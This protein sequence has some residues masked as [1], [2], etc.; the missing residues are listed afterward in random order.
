VLGAAADRNDLSPEQQAEPETL[1]ILNDD[2][3]LCTLINPTDELVS[4]W[5]YAS[6]T[7]RSDRPRRGSTRAYIG[8]DDNRDF[9]MMNMSRAS[10]RTR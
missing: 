2:I 4:N 9:Y 3:I 7:R 8:H 10:T 1:R 5:A 6:R